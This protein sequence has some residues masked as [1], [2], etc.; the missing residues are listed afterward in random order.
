KNNGL[1]PAIAD[2]YALAPRFTPGYHNVTVNLNGKQRNIMPVKFDEEGTPCIDKEFLENAGLIKQTK[3]GTCPKIHQYWSGSTIQTSPDTGEI[4][5]VV[6]PEALDPDYGRQFAEVRGGRAAMLN[7]SMFGTHNR[8]DDDNADRFQSTFE[9]GFNA[10][11]WIVRSTQF[12]SDGSDQDF[13][14]DSLYTYAQRTFTDYG[15][16]VQGGQINVANSRFS[17]PGIYG[18]QMMPD[19]ALTPQAGTGVEV[20]GIA[21]TPQARVDIRQGGQ[22]IYSTLVPAGPFSLDDV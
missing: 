12:I 8:Y 22:L 9:M 18:V 19:T 3:R 1:D 4:S 11:D 14:V 5:V 16:M 20:S 10:G 2:Y 21:R 15:V 7:Y 17:I 13:D 6:P